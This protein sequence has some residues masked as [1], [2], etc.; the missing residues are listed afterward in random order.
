MIHIIKNSVDHGIEPT[1][2]RLRLGKPESG[3][4]YLKASLKSGNVQ[5]Q[6]KDDGRGLSLQKIKEKVLEKK[7]LTTEQISEMTDSE[8]EKLIF[9]PGFSTAAN[10]NE[11]SGRGV[12]MDVVQTNFNKLGGSV[13]IKN[14]EGK[15]LA[16]IA[17]IPQNVTVFSSLIIAAKNMKLAIYQKDILEI[18]DIDSDYYYES[19]E[20]KFYKLRD[21]TIPLVNVSTLLLLE[22]NNISPK[23]IA[24]IQAED[25][26]FGIL[27]DELIGIE[28]IVIKTLGE[29][30]KKI[31]LYDGV[32][33]LGDGKLILVL[34]VFAIAEHSKIHYTIEN[35]NLNEEETVKEDNKFSQFVFRASGQQFTIS[36]SVIYTVIKMLPEDIQSIGNNK[37][38]KFENKVIP[39]VELKTFY[40]QKNIE[41]KEEFIYTIIVIYQEITFGIIAHEIVDITQSLE[42][43]QSDNRLAEFSLGY[44]YIN[45]KLTILIDSEK[46]FSR[47]LKYIEDNMSKME[48]ASV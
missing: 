25:Y 3:N 4:L 16:I 17:T 28:E 22:E 41:F 27:F 11:I 32:A 35:F 43:F 14:E 12:G 46:L 39:L 29:H 37:V 44:A 40:S 19:G 7:L 8:I 24:I 15:G 31:N 48:F 47:I 30:L 10:I 1:E 42:I 21:S 6:I 38:M 13:S 34:N 23:Y 33:V 5:I 2:E 45:E 36:L 26:L 20:H 9:L 18:I